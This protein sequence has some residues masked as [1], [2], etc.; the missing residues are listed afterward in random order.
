MADEWRLSDW[1]A[2]VLYV[3]LDENQE[4]S[5]LKAYA[6][7]GSIPLWMETLHNGKAVVIRASE[8]EQEFL[9]EL[10]EQE[11]LRLAR[12]DES[13]RLP[14]GCEVMTHRSVIQQFRLRNLSP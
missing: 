7:A 3:A 12:M 8:D 2:H 1:E 9:Y 14:C 6:G 10:V 5:R 11:L 13:V 4:S